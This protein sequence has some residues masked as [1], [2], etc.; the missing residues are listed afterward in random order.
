MT[1]TMMIKY[2]EI[3]SRYLFSH[4]KTHTTEI[5]TGNSPFEPGFM[6]KVY[7][8]IDSGKSSY[9]PRQIHSE[10]DYYAKSC[11]KKEFMDNVVYPLCKT[12]V[13]MVPLIAAITNIGVHI[14]DRRESLEV[15]RFPQFILTYWIHL[16]TTTRSSGDFKRLV[17][18]DLVKNN[19]VSII[20]RR[21]DELACLDARQKFL[22][23]Q[24]EN[25]LFKMLCLC[26]KYNLK[27]TY[28]PYSCDF[29]Q[30]NENPFRRHVLTI[31]HIKNLQPTYEIGIDGDP[32]KAGGLS[33]NVVPKLACRDVYG[34]IT[35]GVATLP[36]YAILPCELLRELNWNERK[37]EIFQIYSILSR[38]NRSVSTR[39]LP[40]HIIKI[41]LSYYQKLLHEGSQQRYKFHG[42]NYYLQS[43]NQSHYYIP[44]DYFDDLQS[45]GNKLI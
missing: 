10:W 37:A 1:T 2:K 35:R 45:N 22:D 30:F 38:S 25:E 33:K 8:D 21:K 29:N 16:E 41:I 23:E 36:D 42:K 17:F 39:S 18:I 27:L 24:Y 20:D 9:K 6:L 15:D 5:M 4:N 32:V 28:V 43:T 44:F 7:D 13:K 40:R 19:L 14:P 26:A 12:R 34:F 31:T 3:K 11:A